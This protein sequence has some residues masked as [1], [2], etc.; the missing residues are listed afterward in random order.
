M[1]HLGGGDDRQ[2]VRV[3]VEFQ[4]IIQGRCGTFW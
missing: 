1:V 2:F 3:I 4:R